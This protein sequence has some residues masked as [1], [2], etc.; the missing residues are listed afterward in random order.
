MAF[1]S[2]FRMENLGRLAIFTF[3]AVVGVICFVVL[4][5]V[6]SRLIHV[7]VIGILNLIT[8]YGLLKKRIWVV[9]TIVVLFFITTVFSGFTL[10]YSFER[11]LFL[12]LVMIVYLV[13][14]WLFT[15]YAAT[16][17]RVSTS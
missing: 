15:A 16:R 8:A 11:N 12:N 13:L 10:Y 17:A 3:Y 9:W 2:I 5:I 7:G 1:A 4:A 14:S 6:D